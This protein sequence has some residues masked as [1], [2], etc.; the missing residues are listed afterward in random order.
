MSE[1]SHRHH[2]GRQD[3]QGCRFIYGDPGAGD[4]HYCGRAMAPGG[5][6]G[7]VTHPPYCERHT[8]VCRVVGK[9]FNWA[10][11]S[12]AYSFFFPDV[13]QTLDPDRHDHARPPIDLV[14]RAAENGVISHD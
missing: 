5:K 1:N 9:P 12:K 3:P 6:L 14:L 11:F 8:K 10:R 4:W 2:L 7:D 13:V